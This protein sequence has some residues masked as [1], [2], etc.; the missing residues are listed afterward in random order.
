LFGSEVLAKPWQ[1]S[2]AHQQALLQVYRDF[3]LEDTSDCAHCP[4]PEQLSQWQ[5]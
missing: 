3:C 2:L 4:F 1:K 5:P